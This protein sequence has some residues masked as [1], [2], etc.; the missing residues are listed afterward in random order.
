[1][2]KLALVL[3]IL[4]TVFFSCQTDRN[5]IPQPIIVNDS[6]EYSGSLIAVVYDQNPSLITGAEVRLYTS[7][8]NML[9]GLSTSEQISQAN[10]EANFGSVLVGDYYLTAQKGFK[11]DTVATQVLSQKKTVRNLIIR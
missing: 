4:I 5:D 9:R 3:P 1:M 11:R 7:Y 2:K 6:S 10:G 8:E